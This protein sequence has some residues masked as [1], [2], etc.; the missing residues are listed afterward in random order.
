MILEL[1]SLISD[2]QDDPGQMVA[3]ELGEHPIDHRNPVD[4]NHTL[5]IVC[6]QM[7]QAFA[8][9]GGEDNCLHIVHLYLNND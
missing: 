3:V 9:T 4:L 5:G 1:L 2:N 8:H 7:L 6:R